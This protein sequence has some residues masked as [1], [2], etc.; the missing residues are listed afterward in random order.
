MQE[1]SGRDC[2]EARQIPLWDR[3]ERGLAAFAVK[4]SPTGTD[5]LGEKSLIGLEITTL[6]GTILRFDL[7]ECCG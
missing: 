5:P 1:Q 7:A 2:A 6:S 4:T 3:P